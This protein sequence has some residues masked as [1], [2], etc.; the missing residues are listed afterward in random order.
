MPTVRPI[1]NQIIRVIH[2]PGR[3]HPDSMI[4]HNADQRQLQQHRSLSRS[5]P[6]ADQPEQRNS[7][8]DRTPEVDRRSARAWLLQ[9]THSGLFSGSDALSKIMTGYSATANP[10][11]SGCAETEQAFRNPKNKY[12]A[13]PNPVA[14]ERSGSN[15]CCPLKM[16][17]E[18]CKKIRIERSLKKDFLREVHHRTIWRAS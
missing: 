3:F 16:P 6:T 5:R 14:S 1:P 7:D 4:I 8:R 9:K 18:K 17:I 11:V 13:T 10:A 12:C 15:R 2:R